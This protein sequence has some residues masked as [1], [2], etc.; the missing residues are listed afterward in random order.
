M[1]IYSR[2]HCCFLQNPNK[3]LVAGYYLACNH[4]LE[5]VLT[6]SFVPVLSFQ[7]CLIDNKNKP[8]MLHKYSKARINGLSVFIIKSVP[9][10]PRR[11]ICLLSKWRV[12]VCL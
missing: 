11:L 1:P 6:W 3:I 2:M 5:Q 12:T 7:V 9:F 10:V 8:E 4:V